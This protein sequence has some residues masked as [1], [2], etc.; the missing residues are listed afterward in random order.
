M[1]DLG[2]LSG[3]GRAFSGSR[4]WEP[5]EL[6]A[7]LALERERGVGRS[8][9]ADYIRN[10]IVTLEA[11]DAAKEAEFKPKTLDDAKVAAEAALKDNVFAKPE[12]KPVKVEEPEEKPVKSGKHK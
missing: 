8:T 1:I 4:P 10:G 11:Y 5:E 6:D 3:Q 9:A 12:E 7:L 2:K